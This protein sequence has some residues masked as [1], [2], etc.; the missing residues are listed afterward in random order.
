MTEQEIIQKW[1]ENLSKL[2]FMLN[3]EMTLYANKIGIKNFFTL[4]DYG[5]W[6]DLSRE[7]NSFNTWQIYRLRPDYQPPKP[8]L[9]IV[10]CKVYVNSDNLLTVDYDINRTLKHSY[11]AGCVDIPNFSH[12]EKANGNKIGIENIATEIRN[13]G[14]VWACFEESE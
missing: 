11:L 7:S 9:K 2:G 3:S 1:K 14:K 5:D 12:Y 10:R 8:E 6:V 4:S 13:G